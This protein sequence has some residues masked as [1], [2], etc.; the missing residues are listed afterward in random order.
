MTATPKYAT[1]ADLTARFGEDEL[2]QLT[3]R[4][5]PPLGR[6]NQAVAT[7]ALLDADA[8]IDGFIGSRYTLPL[9]SP[10]AELGRLACDVARYLLY[11]NPTEDVRQRFE[12]ATSYLRDVA[13]GRFNLGL[14]ATGA[15][16]DAT[17]R[18]VMV[19]TARRVFTE[20]RLAG[21]DGAGGPFP[22]GGPWGTGF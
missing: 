22:P 16:P 8:R 4:D 14:D 20:E 9:A 21:F 5:I 6:I 12:D 13:Q 11:R 10:P 15:Q 3:D 17:N 19:S 18:T 7:Q 2:I 1:I